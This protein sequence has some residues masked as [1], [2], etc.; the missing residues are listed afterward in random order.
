VQKSCERLGLSLSRHDLDEV[1]RRM[2]DLAD[3]Q[4]QITDHDLL[5]IATSVC[6]VAAGAGGASAADPSSRI[7]S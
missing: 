7:R 3:R 2:V 5:V 1:Y 6:G 4:K